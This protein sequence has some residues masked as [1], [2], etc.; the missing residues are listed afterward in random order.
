VAPGRPQGV[1]E[2]LAFVERP[3]RLDHVVDERRPP[4]IDRNDVLDPDL[5][6]SCRL[7]RLVH[8]R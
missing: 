1:R 4:A 6:R 5:E 3:R 2:E 8:R 7:Q